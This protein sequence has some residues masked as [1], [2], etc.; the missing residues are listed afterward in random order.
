MSPEN[1]QSPPLE[2]VHATKRRRT[3]KFEQ[4]DENDNRTKSQTATITETLTWKPDQCRNPPTSNRF[5]PIR[6]SRNRYKRR[7]RKHKSVTDDHRQWTFSSRDLS[8]FKGKFVVVSYNILGVE[9]ALKHP[10]LYD[11]EV[12]HFDDLDDLLQM[13]G[14]RG[15]YKA[16]TGDANDGCAIFWKEKL[17]TLLHQ[18]N[19]EFQNFGL[20]HNVAQLCVLK[21]NQSLLESAEESLLSMVSQSQSLVVG[22]IHVLFNPNRGDI[23]LGQIRLFLE[24]AYKLSQEWGGIPVLLAGD[25]NSSPNSALYQFLASSELDVCQHDRR[26]ISGQFAKCRDIEFQKRN[27]T[28]GG[29]VTI[30][31]L[32][33]NWPLQTMVMVPDYRSNSNPLPACSHGEKL[34]F[35]KEFQLH[36]GTASFGKLHYR[37]VTKAMFMECIL[38]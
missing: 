29:A 23:K 22:N 19:I 28:R 9:N 35:R 12:D 4:L 13:D 27:S 10:D 18:E 32:C 6:S 7:K 26:H 21:M 11:K 31:R 14:F 5:E 8:K 16:R 1:R 34:W 36:G 20:R 3:L 25:L 30:L 37:K 38:R 17:F 33:V 15:V 24:K 2:H